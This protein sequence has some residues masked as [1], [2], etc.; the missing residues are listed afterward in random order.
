M[1]MVVQQCECSECH[2]NRHLK[3]VKMVN[4]VLGIFYHNQKTLLYNKQNSPVS[5]I[6]ILSLCLSPIP[7]T[8]VATQ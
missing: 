8:K 1:V 5:E 4:F 3:L 6:I 7:R 2:Q